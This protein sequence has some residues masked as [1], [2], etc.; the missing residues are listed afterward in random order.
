MFSLTDHTLNQ[1]R[2]VYK[3]DD[4]FEVQ[5]A[6]SFFVIELDQYVITYLDVIKAKETKR[7]LGSQFIDDLAEFLEQHM[8]GNPKVKGAHF[9][10]GQSQLLK[11]HAFFAKQGF[12]PL[13]KQ[14]EDLKL[15]ECDLAYRQV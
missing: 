12:G 13:P 2:T 11:P 9:L 4:M 3:V 10:V 1:L 14:F 6:A 8:K 7:G 5:F 15:D